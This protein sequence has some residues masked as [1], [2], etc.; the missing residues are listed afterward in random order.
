[1]PSTAHHPRRMVSLLPYPLPSPFFSFLLFLVFPPLPEPFHPPSPAHPPC[2]P[3]PFHSL[4]LC[5]CSELSRGASTAAALATPGQCVDPT[6]LP[7]SGHPS[8][9]PSPSLS[10]FTPCPSDVALQASK[11]SSRGSLD[12]AP[13]DLTDFDDEALMRSGRLSIDVT[14]RVESLT[15][16][17]KVAAAAVLLLLLLLL[18]DSVLL[19]LLT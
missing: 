9:S 8:I 5:A 10:F 14:K 18:P 19:A 2:F 15:E 16:V 11:S 13:S 12:F 1:M 6:C 7:P 17:C 4:C 3:P